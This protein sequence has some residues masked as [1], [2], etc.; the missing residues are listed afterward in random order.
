MNRIQSAAGVSVL[1]ACNNDKFLLETLR[2][3]RD[4]DFPSEKIELVLIESCYRVG[5][6]HRDYIRDNFVNH[7]ILQ[8]SAPGVVAAR[9]LGLSAAVFDLVAILDADDRMKAGRIALQVKRFQRCPGLVALGGQI[10]FIDEIGK[11]FDGGHYHLS[12][13]ILRLNMVT[14]NP[15][16]HPATM[17]L[18]SAVMAVG[19]YRE[20]V[21][22]DWDLCIR[23]SEVG[24]IQNLKN[25]VIDYRQ[26]SDQL[27]RTPLYTSKAPRE[28]MFESAMIRRLKS[29]DEFTERLV[30][31]E[32]FKTDSLDS[33]NSADLRFGLIQLASSLSPV[34]FRRPIRRLMLKILSRL[35]TLIHRDLSLKQVTRIERMYIAIAN[36]A[37]RFTKLFFVRLH[38]KSHIFLSKGD[39]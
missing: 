33:Q 25:C 2:S 19:G 26:S 23:L 1:I 14:A 37:S 34:P 16:A 4:Q 24:L 32:E 11:P 8:C 3:V 27:S 30:A 18:K 31:V 35:S 39:S 10:Q 38:S 29:G 21:P 22:E 9:N 17:L 20:G 12:D 5:S 15:L 13:F 36:M 7:Q 28:K 6:V